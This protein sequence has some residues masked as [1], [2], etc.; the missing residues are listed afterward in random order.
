MFHMSNYP[1]LEQHLNRPRGKDHE[2]IY[3]VKKH[4]RHCGGYKEM[5][6]MQ[7]D[8]PQDQLF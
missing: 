5:G 6:V 8:M 4:E 1:L 2:Y 7:F 3:G